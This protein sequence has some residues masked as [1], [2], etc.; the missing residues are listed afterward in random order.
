MVKFQTVIIPVNVMEKVYRR[1]FYS[2]S[3]ITV[4]QVTH[5]PFETK[6]LSDALNFIVLIKEIIFL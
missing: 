4:E 3:Q 6:F 5:R 2:N 1:L